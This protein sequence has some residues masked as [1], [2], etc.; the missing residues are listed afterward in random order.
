MSRKNANWL[1]AACVW[2]FFVW[3]VA[4]KNLVVNDHTTGFRVVHATLAAVSLGFG[5]FVGR[6]GWNARKIS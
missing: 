6:L 2:T 3:T 5:A 1:L 4:V